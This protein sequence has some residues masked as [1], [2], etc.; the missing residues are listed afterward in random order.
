MKSKDELKQDGVRIAALSPSIL[1][2]PSAIR[3]LSG[4]TLLELVLAMALVSLVAITL[5]ASVRIAFKARQGAEEAIEPSRTAS[6]AMEF[7]R[8]DLESAQP[9]RETLI[10]PFVGYDSTDAR[11]RGADGVGF[12]S[13]AAGPRQEFGSGEIKRVELGVELLPNT[14]G[15]TEQYGLVRRVTSNL[16]A[17]QLPE[18]DVE[19][20]CRGV[21]AFE[22]EYYDPLTGW[23]ASWDSSQYEDS[24]PSAVRVT[25]EL[26]RVTG[27]AADDGERLPV[28]FSRVF[29]IPCAGSSGTEAGGG[30]GE[31]ATPAT[32]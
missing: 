20:L 1:H 17:P 3:R 32:E 8:M 6:L 12:F 19:V 29:R 30:A 11:G 23:V 5:F 22:V 24:L 25:L 28:R 7:L 15:G 27:G 2:P 26:D 13:T 10:G 16:L 14:V 21:G 31:G 18:P 9:P 4:F